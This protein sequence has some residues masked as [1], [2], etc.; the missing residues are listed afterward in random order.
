VE[1]PELR[2][3]IPPDWNVPNPLELYVIEPEV[4]ETDKS[5]TEVCVYELPVL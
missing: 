2:V 3:M 5:P 1:E 4:A